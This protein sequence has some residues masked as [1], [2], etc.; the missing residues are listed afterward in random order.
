MTAT[1][2][3]LPVTAERSIREV[4]RDELLV[5]KEPDFDAITDAVLQQLD[6]DQYAA[7]ARHGVRDQ[8]AEEAAQ[9]RHRATRPG[10]RKRSASPR[11]AKREAASKSA[12]RRPELFASVILVGHEDDGANRLKFLGDCAAA[13]LRAAAEIQR[14]LGDSH[15]ARAYKTASQYE[16]LARKLHKGAL[17]NSLSVRVVEAV[18]SD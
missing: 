11:S 6:D 2:A 4:I 12:K 15:Q 10:K 17:V 8:V 9:H 16:T 14:T 13:D 18:F 3:K 5:A 1:A 7:A